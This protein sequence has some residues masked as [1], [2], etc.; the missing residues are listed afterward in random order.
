VGHGGTEKVK[1]WA[2]CSK[3]EFQAEFTRKSSARRVSH[4]TDDAFYSI[5]A[6]YLVTWL[7]VQGMCKTA[8]DP[9]SDHHRAAQWRDGSQEPK[10]VS[11]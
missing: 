5:I 10:S 1:T 9:P 2:G 11:I 7:S 6:M 3:G 8:R 4:V